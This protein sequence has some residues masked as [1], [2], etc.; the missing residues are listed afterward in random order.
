VAAQ[1]CERGP[2]AV[3]VNNGVIVTKKAWEREPEE[4]D[5][6]RPGQLLASAFQSA[7]CVMELG[8]FLRRPTCRF[9][10]ELHR[11]HELFDVGQLAEVAAGPLLDPRKPMPGGVDMDGK[12]FRRG[13]CIEVRRDVRKQRANEY[14]ASRRILLDEPTNRR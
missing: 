4:L 7:W 8:G 10:C 5:P 14:P 12:E 2:L 13:L 1:A 9:R 6:D 11:D 3:W